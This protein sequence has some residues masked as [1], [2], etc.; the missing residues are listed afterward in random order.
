MSEDTE[1]LPDIDLGF[2]CVIRDELLVRVH[3]Q[4]GP[5]RAAIVGAMAATGGAL[6]LPKA[7][8]AHHESHRAG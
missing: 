2:P 1:T 7:N 3:K 8:L 4:F 6:G 5:E